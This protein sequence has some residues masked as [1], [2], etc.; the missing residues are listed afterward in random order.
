MTRGV[1]FERDQQAEYGSTRA[2]SDLTK[3]YSTKVF[4]ALYVNTAYISLLELSSKKG[5]NRYPDESDD[6]PSSEAMSALVPN[7]SQQ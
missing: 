4:W 1:L 7:W 6:G 3:K 5:S 2:F